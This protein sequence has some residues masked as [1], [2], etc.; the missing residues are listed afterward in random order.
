[1][2]K[3]KKERQ[4][5][6]KKG[7]STCGTTKPL[8]IIKTPTDLCKC[9]ICTCPYYLSL[10]PFSETN[11]KM[12]L[13]RKKSTCSSTDGECRSQSSQ[14]SNSS[15][16]SCL[17]KAKVEGKKRLYKVQTSAVREEDSDSDLSFDNSLPVAGT[18]AEQSVRITP[19][20]RQ[21]AHKKQHINSPSPKKHLHGTFSASETESSGVVPAELQSIFDPP[22]VGDYLANLLQSDDVASLRWDNALTCTPFPHLTIPAMCRYIFAQSLRGSVSDVSKDKIVNLYDFLRAAA[23]AGVI[24]TTVSHSQQMLLSADSD[25][26]AL[27]TSHIHTPVCFRLCSVHCLYWASRERKVVKRKLLQARSR[28]WF[29]RSTT[30]VM[31]RYLSGTKFQSL[32]YEIFR[33]VSLRQKDLYVQIAQT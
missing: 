22:C 24:R 30:V 33:G 2:R 12:P 15:S 27:F 3:K 11:A 9:N 4:K 10:G 16:T 17:S 8:I 25:T 31:S 1:M 18:G 6:K 26:Y 7:T 13:V 23:D 20:K 5:K 14:G 21:R 28:H 32:F 19:T 29:C